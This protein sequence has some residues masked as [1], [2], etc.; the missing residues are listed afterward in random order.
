MLPPRRLQALLCQAVEHQKDRCPYHNS[1]H[2]TGLDGVSLLTDHV[3]SR[4]DFPSESH[5]IITDHVDEVWYCAFSNDGTML[6]TG[7]KDLTVIVWDIDEVES[8]ISVIT[9]SPLTRVV[10]LAITENL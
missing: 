1:V 3:C 5:Q 8:T 2:D 4:E 10:L 9:A 6:A 7:S